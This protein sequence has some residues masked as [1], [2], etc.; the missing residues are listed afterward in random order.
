VSFTNKHCWTRTNCFSRFV[1]PWSGEVCEHDVS[2]RSGWE[3]CICFE[4]GWSRL[5]GAADAHTAVAVSLK[6]S[7]EKHSSICVGLYFRVTC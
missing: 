2:E 3:A 6:L 4:L 1:D 5:P 7:P